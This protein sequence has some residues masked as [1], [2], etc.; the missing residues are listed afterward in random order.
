[1]SGGNALVQISLPR[2]PKKGELVVSLNGRD[3]TAAFRETSPDTFVGLVDG[4]ALGDNRLTA[5]AKGVGSKSLR[6][7]N[8]PITGPIVSGPH[9]KVGPQE[10]PFFCQTGTF[11]LPDGST[12]GPALDAD[13]SAATKVTYVYLPRGGTAFK[14]LPTWRRPPRSPA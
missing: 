11:L 10:R 1:V 12:F 13:C 9:G 8:Y 3:V 6:L 2:A 5:A 7:V 14:P 4:L